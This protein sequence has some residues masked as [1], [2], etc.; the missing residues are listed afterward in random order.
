MTLPVREAG[1]SPVMENPV[2]TDLPARALLAVDGEGAPEDHPFTAAV[3]ALFAVRAALGAPADVPLEGTYAQDGDPLRFDL[4]APAGWHWTLALPA[5]PDRSAAAVATAGERFG[6][7]VELR[8]EPARRVAELLHRGPYA[9][10]RPSLDALYGFVAAQGLRPAG[11]HTEVY[12]TDPATTAP[13]D[14]RTVLRVPV[15]GS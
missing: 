12:L 14:N 1:A 3:R 6:A 8:A 9:D 13:A 2:L 15:L 10:E 7:P 11:P 5:P 4:D